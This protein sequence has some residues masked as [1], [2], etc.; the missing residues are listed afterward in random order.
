MKKILQKLNPKN[1]SM[2]LQVFL[3]LFIVAI[4]LII[5]EFCL[6]NNAKNKALQS[7]NTNEEI[8]GFY[9]GVTPSD[10]LA[11]ETFMNKTNYIVISIENNN[12]TNSSFNSLSESNEVRQK[13]LTNT[14]N[15]TLIENDVYFTKVIVDS[16]YVYVYQKNYENITLEVIVPTLITTSFLDSLSLYQS[17]LLLGMVAL[18]TLVAVIFNYMYV[19]PIKDMAYVAS[20]IK[21]QNFAYY[22]EDYYN[23]DYDRL[24]HEINEVSNSLKSVIDNLNYKNEE[25]TRYISN[26]EKD[27]QFQKQLVATISHEI[28]TPLAVMQATISGII[29]GIF[30]GDD[31]IK[32]LNNLLVEI[33][34]T[35]KMLQE[36][37]GIYK[38]ETSS[39]I[40][41]IKSI[42]LHQLINNALASLEKIAEKYHQEI[43][44]TNTSDVFINADAKQMERVLNNI[45]LNAITYSPKNSRIEIDL[46][47]K[48]KYY[49][50]EV[51]NYGVT[52]NPKDLEKIFEPFY[53][54][55]KSRTKKEDH[56]NGLGLY[57]VKQILEKHNFDYGMEN[58]SDGVKFY[59]IFKK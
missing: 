25:I 45:I 10:E 40:L 42:N 17:L 32:E 18:F 24:G 6:T 4:I 20:K 16:N 1:Y 23:S 48:S 12:L 15:Y 8:V 34:S 44:Y 22:A 59:C 43:I 54:V 5:T 41:E 33:E 37:V 26:Q 39:F 30:T 58:L 31:A 21:K 3:I 38:M 29:D 49:L 35:N 47:D 11:I 14:Y 57:L 7:D 50:L 36:I 19:R 53:R 46:L 52:I 28:K 27:Y 13:V 51:K 56:G 9:N 2:A 55:D